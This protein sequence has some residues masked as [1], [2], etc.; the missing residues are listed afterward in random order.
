[1]SHMI[2]RKHYYDDLVYTAAIFQ[3][4]EIWATTGINLT[5]DEY[6]YFMQSSNDE[7]TDELL[8]LIAD[9]SIIFKNLDEIDESDPN[10]C[11]SLL[12][13]CLSHEA[14][15][16]AWYAWRKNTIGGS[17]RTCSPDE[18]QSSGL[19]MDPIFGTPYSFSSLDNA[20]LHV[21][22]WIAMSMTQRLISKARSYTYQFSAE[23]GS[24]NKEYLLAEFFADEISR[25]IPYCFKDCTNLWNTH[26]VSMGVG[27]ICKV[28]TDHQNYRKFLWGQQAYGIIAN[29]GHEL[30]TRLSEVFWQRWNAAEEAAASSGANPINYLSLRPGFPHEK[31]LSRKMPLRF[32]WPEQ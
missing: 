11:Q 16:M 7:P 24:G 4:L 17:P 15:V 12:S 6:S 28:Y 8:K 23:D 31:S 14:N 27:Q 2:S 13:Q 21:L 5:A 29:L 18:I 9:F 32:K 20:R 30:A 19:S 10:A 25:A 1:M 3:A 26:I 22:F